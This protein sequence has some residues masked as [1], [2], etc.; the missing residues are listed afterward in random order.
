M[1]A[2]D[3]MKLYSVIFDFHDVLGAELGED[4]DDFVAEYHF[5]I[6]TIPEEPTEKEVLVGKGKLS[7]IQFG[8]AMDAKFPLL[9]VMDASSTILAMSQSLFSWEEDSHPFDKLDEHFAE[10][11]ILNSNICFVEQIQ[12]LPAFRGQGTG[13]AM[14]ISIARKFYN[15]CGLIVLK[16]FPLQHEARHPGEA[17]AWTKAMRYDELEQDLEHAQHQ[18]FNWYQKMGLKNPFD[19]EY[20]IA[21]PADLAHLPMFDKDKP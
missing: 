1:Q 21:R 6:H 4:P 7:L 17:D 19:E 3:E 2:E 15:S 10:D 12:I 8:L 5:K 9:D 11:P 16:A 20:F 18:L 14:L 13:R